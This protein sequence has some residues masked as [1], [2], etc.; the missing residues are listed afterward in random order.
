MGCGAGTPET[1][2]AT[3][4]GPTSFSGKFAMFWLGD[5]STGGTGPNPA[6]GGIIEYPQADTSTLELYIQDA[7]VGCARIPPGQ[8]M[9]ANL[10]TILVT[11]HRLGHGS[12]GAGEYPLIGKPGDDVREIPGVD[13]IALRG[14]CLGGSEVTDGHLSLSR[15]SPEDAEGSL[16]IVLGD[17][18]HVDGAFHAERC[19]DYWLV[20][21]YDP[22]YAT[23]RDCNP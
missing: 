23:K 3:R 20:A 2:V 18:T 22:T 16:W 11:V 19:A 21:P 6:D 15:V 14:D 7:A 8:V 13:Y 9:P 17:G 10:S 4:S 5:T 1:A 12:L